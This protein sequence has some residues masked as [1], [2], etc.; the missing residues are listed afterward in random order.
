MEELLKQLLEGQRQIIE[1]QNKLEQSNEK[2]STDI[3]SVKLDFARMEQ[4][5]GRKTGLL[6]DG[7]TQ[8]QE[9]FSVLEEGIGEIGE[10]L[11]R[12]DLTMVKIS[13]IQGKQSNILDTLSVRSVEQEAEIR[14]FKI[15][16]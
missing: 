2:L 14:S 12:I 15:V 6:L 11:E 10:T 1:S 7:W 4:E 13:S 9:R 3:R 5:V 16:K 8:H